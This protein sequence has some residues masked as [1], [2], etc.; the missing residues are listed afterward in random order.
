MVIE[1]GIAMLEECGDLLSKRCHSDP[2]SSEN[3]R[4]RER[5]ERDMEIDV[6]FVKAAAAC[7]I[8]RLLVRPGRRSWVPECVLHAVQQHDICCKGLKI[9]GL[10]RPRASARYIASQMKGY[11]VDRSQTQLRTQGGTLPILAMRPRIRFGLFMIST[12]DAQPVGM[13]YRGS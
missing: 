4:C 11:Y 6:L 8:G 12:K 10:L 7:R 9:F 1:E 5:T 2:E 13:V 3:E